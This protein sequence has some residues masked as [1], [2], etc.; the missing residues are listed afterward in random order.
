MDPSRTDPHTKATSKY[1]QPSQADR[2]RRILNNHL[3]GIEKIRALNNQLCAWLQQPSPALQQKY[4]LPVIKLLNDVCGRNFM[5]IIGINF[6]R[7]TNISG[8]LW[9][10]TSPY[11]NSIDIYV[12]RKNFVAAA[13]I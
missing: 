7:I 13:K 4:N 5:S 10:F 11:R 1:D 6:A 3:S 9:L 12:T 8:H 2:H